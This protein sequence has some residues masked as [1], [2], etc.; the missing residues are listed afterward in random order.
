[1]SKL[2][3]SI[4]HLLPFG[5]LRRQHLI[6]RNDLLLL[7]QTSCRLAQG[8]RD[9]IGIVEQLSIRQLLATP[10]HVVI[11]RDH[12]LALHRGLDRILGRLVV[13]LGASRIP[14]LV[15]KV[16]FDDFLGIF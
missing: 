13:V 12:V 10:P 16:F 1:M 7:H 11:V 15:E 5:S 9:R 4:L 14:L 2:L 6:Q 8:Y 3:Q